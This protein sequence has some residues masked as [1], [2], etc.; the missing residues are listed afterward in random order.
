MQRTGIAVALSFALFAEPAAAT[1]RGFEAIGFVNRVRGDP[2]LLPLSFEQGVGLEIEL[3]FRVDDAIADGNP[4]NPDT[5]VYRLEYLA[6][7]IG[8][9]T[10]VF[11][12]GPSGDGSIV[13]QAS[14]VGAQSFTLSG[15]RA[16]CEGGDYDEA[17]FEIIYSDPPFASDA[18]TVPTMANFD[19]IA[20]FRIGLFSS[21]SIAELETELFTLPFF[22]VREVPEPAQALSLG[23]G[24]LI[25]AAAR[26]A[27][28]AREHSR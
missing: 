7:T 20:S 23:I 11:V 22:M 25:L 24:A 6:A 4:G 16:E 26:R 17:F 18:I 15:C 14:E 2:E 27:F 3:E 13:I 21:D 10:A 5:G 9:S 12:D 8:G 28:G 1:L 19:E